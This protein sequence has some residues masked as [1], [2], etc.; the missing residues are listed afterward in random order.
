MN[1]YNIKCWKVSIIS[2]SG[3][4]FYIIKTRRNVQLIPYEDT[5][6]IR[7]WEFRSK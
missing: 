6:S 2:V 5:Y 4:A 1:R 7:K 3:N